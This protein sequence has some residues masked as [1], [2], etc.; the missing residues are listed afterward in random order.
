M[1]KV[2]HSH[3]LLP[4]CCPQSPGLPSP[5]YTHICV[6]RKIK[7]ANNFFIIDKFLNLF[8]PTPNGIIQ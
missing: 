5:A 8:P 4:V 1:I 3:P 7:N 6:I 2:A